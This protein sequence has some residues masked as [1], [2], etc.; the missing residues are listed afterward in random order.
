MQN[1]M[2]SFYLFLILCISFGTLIR[3]DDDPIYKHLFWTDRLVSYLETGSLLKQLLDN[4]ETGTSEPIDPAFRNLL[5]QIVWLGQVDISKCN[6]G[7][8][9]IVRDLVATD[10]KQFG[11]QSVDLYVKTVGKRQLD[12]CKAY[13]FA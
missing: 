13:G 7:S 10:F 6:P 9:K 2:Y 1:N 3:A 11:S 4:Y 8:L 5:P 12:S